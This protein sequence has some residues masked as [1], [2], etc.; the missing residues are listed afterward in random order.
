[1]TGGFLSVTEA[2]VTVLAEDCQP[3]PAAAAH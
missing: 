2:G 3:T 1:V